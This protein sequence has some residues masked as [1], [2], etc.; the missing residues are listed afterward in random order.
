M[1]KKRV[2]LTG[3]F[4]VSLIVFLAASAFAQF[5]FDSNAG[6]SCIKNRYKPFSNAVTTGAAMPFDYAVLKRGVYSGGETKGKK[7]LTLNVNK[8]RVILEQRQDLQLYAKPMDP[9]RLFII[10]VAD[11]LGM[12]EIN[13]GGGTIFGVEKTD[14]RPFLGHIRIGL[15]GVAEIEMTTIGVINQLS[16]GSPSIPTA[17]FKLK[18]IS[19][20]VD[21]WRPAI[22]GALRSS[23]W[24]SE[25]GRD[26]FGKSWKFQKRI[27]T[28]YFVASKTFGTSSLHTGISISD[29]RIRTKDA[30]TD[31]IF[32]PNVEEIE[33]HDKDYINKNLFRPFIGLRVE[34]N[35]RTSLMIEGEYIAQYK[36]DEDNPKLTN[37]DIGTEFM[38]IAGV[39]FFFFNWLSMD[40]G[41]MYRSDFHGIGDALIDAGVD[42]N[43][44]MRK[45]AKSWGF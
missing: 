1:N 27:S 37:N 11:V 24:H 25:I 15:G 36:F 26:E 43:L 32:S 34:V 8:S 42:I 22:A 44:P 4:S 41:V 28:L 17:A 30:V 18:F 14:K 5:Q 21:G 16:E 7:M 38:L 20:D 35:P 10:P 23:L 9:K 29:L 12:Y 39:R 3:F 33:K 31:E 45:I 6:N 13:T 19:E 40:T 2:I